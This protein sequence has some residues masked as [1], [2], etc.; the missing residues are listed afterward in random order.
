MANLQAKRYRLQ[1]RTW[2]ALIALIALSTVH[3]FAPIKRRLHCTSA[4]SVSPR[5]TILTVPRLSKQTQIL[6]SADDDA[7]ESDDFMASLKS[8]MAEVNDR[9]TKLPLVVLDTMLPRQVLKIQVDNPLLLELV[10]TCLKNETPFFGMLGMARLAT[11]QS[12]HL[13]R[14]V[15]VE[16]LD[17]KFLDGG[18]SIRLA[19]RGGRRFEILGEIE[20][21][22]MGWTEA[23]VQFLDFE[24]EE[25]REIH[26]KDRMTVARAISKATELTSPNMR[27]ENNLSLIDRWIELAKTVEREP[28]Q[29]DQL[30]KDLGEMPPPEEPSDL[31]FWVGA[32]INPIPAM[33]VATEIRPA[34]LTAKKTEERVQVAIDGIFKS[35]R[36]MDG[37]KRIW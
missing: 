6:A 16:I 30:L 24:Q 17:T 19:L 9:E 22:G 28:G 35:I 7:N 18:K 3:A 34:L 13:K 4:P 33:G 15:E 31:A 2:A 11:G 14:G 32:L 27:M 25:E 23:R 37:T 5:K 36:H 29:I 26:G 8:R 21:A 10:R 12:V 20:T 1:L